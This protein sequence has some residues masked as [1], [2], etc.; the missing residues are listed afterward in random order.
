[1]LQIFSLPKAQPAGVRW[2]IIPVRRGWNF[3]LL[4]SI[5]GKQQGWERSSSLPN[6]AKSKVMHLGV[7]CS[8]GREKKRSEGC[9]DVI[10]GATF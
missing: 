7:S 6:S 8:H 2:G 4:V 9:L 10:A 5:Q 3:F 1:M